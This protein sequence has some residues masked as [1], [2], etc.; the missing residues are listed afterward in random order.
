MSG[1]REYEI[2]HT[3]YD[4]MVCDIMEYDVMDARGA[5]PSY[6]G[7]LQNV[8]IISGS[9]KAMKQEYKGKATDGQEG[10]QRWKVGKLNSGTNTIKV[11]VLVAN[12]APKTQLF[13]PVHRDT[14]KAPVESEVVSHCV[15]ITLTSHNRKSPEK[16]CVDFIRRAKEKNLKGRCTCLLR[17]R[18]SLQEKHLGVKVPRHGIIS[19]WEFTSDSPSKIVEQ[20]TSISIEPGMEI[21]ITFADA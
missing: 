9:R 18:E 4:L 20:I 17:H 6:L 5:V 8:L 15:P 16:V 1:V 3:E 11:A 12:C 19:K 14:G 13:I 7:Q 21:K 10:C 2:L